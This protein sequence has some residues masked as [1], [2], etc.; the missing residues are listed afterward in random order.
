[1]HKQPRHPRLE[2]LRDFRHRGKHPHCGRKEC[3]ACGVFYRGWLRADRRNA[4]AALR[5]DVQRA[6]FC[7]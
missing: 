3:G 5:T 4:K 2:K 7:D 1:M 6:A